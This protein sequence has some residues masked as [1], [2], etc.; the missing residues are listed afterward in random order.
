MTSLTVPLSMAAATLFGH[1][2]RWCV[3]VAGRAVHTIHTMSYIGLCI[4][5]SS[6]LHKRV[7]QQSDTRQMILPLL[8]QGQTNAHSSQCGRWSSDK[9]TMSYR[10]ILPKMKT[11][12]NCFPFFCQLHFVCESWK[13]WIIRKHIDLS[14]DVSQLCRGKKETQLAIADWSCASLFEPFFFCSLAKKEMNAWTGKVGWHTHARRTQINIWSHCVLYD[15]ILCA[16]QLHNK[17][18]VK[19]S[20]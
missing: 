18:Y 19:L 11:I 14:V 2:V 7:V 20:R 4:I 12:Q 6:S 8:I 17:M 10:F 3:N 9:D 13:P 15:A 5:V 16:L 1:I